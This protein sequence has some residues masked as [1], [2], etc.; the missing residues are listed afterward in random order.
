MIWTL[1]VA[2]L[3]GRYAKSACIRIIEIDSSATLE[4]LHLAIQ[5]A[6]DFDNDHL[7]EF[8]IARTDHS[9][10]KVRCDCDNEGRI[11]LADLFPLPKGRKLFYYFDYGDSWVFEVS[12]TRKA[13]FAPVSGVAYPIVI[14]KIGENPEQYLPAD[15]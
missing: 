11:M 1:K 8:F 3:A 2:L 10:E 5:K 13:P 6:V 9:R 14:E 7:Y 15:W 4:Y 12:R